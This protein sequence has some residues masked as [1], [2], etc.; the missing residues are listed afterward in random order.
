VLSLVHGYAGEA[1]AAG[2]GADDGH[3]L[4]VH[5]VLANAREVFD[6]G[7]AQLGEVGGVADAGELENLRGV[8]GAAG[9]D[10]FAPGEDGALLALGVGGA[11]VVAGVGR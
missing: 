4:V 1:G 11:A 5:E 6:D 2:T 7:D 10:D 9:D 3:L 8:E